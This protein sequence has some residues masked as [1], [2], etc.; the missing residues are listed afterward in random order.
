MDALGPREERVSTVTRALARV[1]CRPCP[2]L[3]AARSRFS[4]GH[5][6]GPPR[7]A[8]GPARGP[9]R[10]PADPRGPFRTPADPR[11]PAAPRGSPRTRA[12]PLGPARTRPRGNQCRSGLG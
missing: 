11:G 8:R 9:P 2:L 12:D 10:T 1:F 4:G 5:P 7:T 6:R 3:V